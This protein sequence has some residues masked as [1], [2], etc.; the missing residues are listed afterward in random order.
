MENKESFNKISLQIWS[1]RQIL[2]SITIA[3]IRGQW[4][5]RPKLEI[6]GVGNW[7]LIKAL[8]LFGFISYSYVERK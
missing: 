3:A 1:S 4:L 8:W 5:W 2:N 6:T 7:H